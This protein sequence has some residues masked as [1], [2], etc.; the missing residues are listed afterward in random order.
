MDGST[1][2]TP[3]Q[4]IAEGID[5]AITTLDYIEKSWEAVLD[6]PAYLQ[7][8]LDLG[9]WGMPPKRPAC[10]FGTAF[11]RLMGITIKR[12][13][14]DEAHLVKDRNAMPHRALKEVNYEAVILLAGT[15]AHERFTDVDGLTSFLDGHFAA[16]EQRFRHTFRAAG[17][18]SDLLTWEDSGY[19]ARFLRAFAICRYSGVLK[20]PPMVK[21][22]V[23][24]ELDAP[25]VK[26][27]DKHLAE[28]NKIKGHGTL[29]GDSEKKA[30]HRLVG[31]RLG[32]Y[33][34][35]P[36]GQTRRAC[37]CDL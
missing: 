19:F 20:L 7:H 6:Y 11:W 26:A 4:L 23:P 16:T 3:T 30:I 8:W 29:S 18:S 24:F 12:L 33:F 25:S 28:F 36:Q 2:I 1:D 32:L 31:R 14:I 15:T 10:V 37:R 27:F 21:Y 5:V 35:D 22:S 9:R 13:V 17:A 34:T